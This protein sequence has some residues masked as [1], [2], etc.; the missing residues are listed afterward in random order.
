MSYQIFQILIP[1]L[2]SKALISIYILYGKQYSVFLK[3]AEKYLGFT[4]INLD[5]IQRN[6]INSRINICNTLSGTLIVNDKFLNKIEFE[7]DKTTRIIYIC[8]IWIYNF[9]E[10]SIFLKDLTSNFFQYYENGSLKLEN[11]KN[12]N[13]YLMFFRNSFALN[14]EVWTIL[15]D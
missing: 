1:F 2:D 14:N 3:E 15:G 7:Y 10:Y 9:K 5:E 4:L 11:M 12:L 8:N 13:C 6:E